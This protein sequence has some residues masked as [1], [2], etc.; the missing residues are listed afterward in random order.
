M[1]SISSTAE[2]VKAST[3]GSVEA[4]TKSSRIWMTGVQQISKTMAGMA[5][6]QF[7][8]NMQAF[9]ALGGVRSL[10]EAMEW[11]KQHAQHYLQTAIADGSAITHATMKLNEETLAP[12]TAHIAAST[13]SM[14]SKSA[15]AA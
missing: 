12:I 6:A 1:D 11:Q 3:E 2:N 8:S 14:L 10:A 5:K 13:K 7:D 4:M 15:H 9:T